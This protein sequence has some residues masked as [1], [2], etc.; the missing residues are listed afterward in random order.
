MVL[1]F[2]LVL[3]LLV[4]GLFWFPFSRIFCFNFGVYIVV[5]LFYL[6]GCSILVY[7][8]TTEKWPLWK[9]GHRWF[10]FNYVRTY[11]NTAKQKNPLIL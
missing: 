10:S 7:I 5:D 6:L 8:R 2:S 9:E 1:E 3:I 4:L 11:I